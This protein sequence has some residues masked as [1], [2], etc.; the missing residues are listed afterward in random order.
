MDPEM[1]RKAEDFFYDNIGGALLDN[2]SKNLVPCPHCGR[3]FNYCK[4]KPLNF[5]NYVRRELE[6]HPNL[7]KI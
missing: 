2:F 1:Q 4:Y 7:C 5:A 3:K 6:T